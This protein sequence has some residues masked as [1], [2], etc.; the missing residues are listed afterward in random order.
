MNSTAPS[1]SKPAG[2]ESQGGS[3]NIVTWF[4]RFNLAGLGI[5]LPLAAFH[6]AET[7]HATGFMSVSTRWK[8]VL[9]LVIFA[10]V[11]LLA[12][13]ATS[14]T[15]HWARIVALFHRIELGLRKLGFANLVLALACAAL[16]AWIIFGIKIYSTLVTGY[17]PRLA[18]LWVAGLVAGILIRAS[19]PSI[20]PLAALLGGVMLCGVTLQM[21]DLFQNVNNYPFTQGWSETSRYYYGSLLFSRQV[22]GEAVPL[23]PWHASRYFLLSIPYL[24]NGLPLWAHRLWQQLLWFG[25]SALSGWALARRMSHTGRFEKI[26]A[27]GWVF[28]FLFLGPVYYHLQICLVIVLLGFKLRHPGRTWIAVLLASIWAGFSRVNWTPVP[29][30]LAIVLYCLENRYPRG[31]GPVANFISY[32]FRP[33]VWLVSGMGVALA[34]Q[35]AYQGISGQPDLSVFSS[36]FTSDLLWYRLVASHIYSPGILQ[37]VGIISAPLLLVIGFTVVSQGRRVHWLR[38]LCLAAILLVLLAGGLV[39]STKVGG[40]SNLHNL[41]AFLAFVMISAALIAAGNMNL[42]G[43]TPTP[44]RRVHWFPVALAA[45]IPMLWLLQAYRPAP[46][47]D[48][49]QAAED[50]RTVQAAVTQAG[51]QNKPVLFIMQRHLVT[52]NMVDKAPFVQEYELLTLMEMSISGNQNYLDHYVQDLA[53]HRFGL[54]ISD[55]QNTPIK[56]PLRDA[57]AEENNAWVQ[58]VVIPTLKYYRVKQSLESEIDLL[59]PYP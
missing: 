33:V 58:R 52:F 36:T 44:I 35:A 3:K 15:V 9:G 40:G 37:A 12:L 27:T 4:W 49:V 47:R 34:A 39:V 8:L 29:A 19:F 50:L 7:I 31:A 25:L 5:L 17:L 28:L 13:L 45:F 26:L 59:I 23:S 42:D 38:W 54:I 48:A 57:F 10:G 43:D 55:H 6:L 22:Y 56:D 2:A 11:I 30:A 41:D 24:V 16:L 18:L 20:F 46:V 14:F 21:V 32:F 51:S 53:N 1:I